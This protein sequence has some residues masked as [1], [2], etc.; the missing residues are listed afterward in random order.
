MNLVTR[1]DRRYPLHERG[2]NLCPNRVPPARCY[3]PIDDYVLIWIDKEEPL[4]VDDFLS[5][6]FVSWISVFYE[7][8]A[9]FQRLYTFFIRCQWYLP[10]NLG[11]HFARETRLSTSVLV[12]MPCFQPRGLNYAANFSFLLSPPPYLNFRA[13]HIDRYFFSFFSY[14]KY[15]WN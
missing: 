3:Y 14:T 7:K 10:C 12:L 15:R 9:R 13:R 4:L 1:S 6:F 5:N 8:P 11:L 2:A